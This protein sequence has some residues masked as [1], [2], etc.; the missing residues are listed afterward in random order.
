VELNFA[1]GKNLISTKS[2]YVWLFSRKSNWRLKVFTLSK[3]SFRSLLF[4]YFHGWKMFF[5]DFAEFN[6]AIGKFL[7]FS[8]I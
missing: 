7:D 5:Y 4:F 1:V 6:V 8:G 3:N 2:N